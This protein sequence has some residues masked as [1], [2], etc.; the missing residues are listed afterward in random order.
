MVGALRGLGYSIMP[1]IV[2]LLGACAFRLVWLATIF[3][4]DMFHTIEMVYISYPVSWLLTFTTHL[5][6]FIIV[7]RKLAKKWGR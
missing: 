4:A 2:S 6:C 3:Q 7:R 1:M 5:I